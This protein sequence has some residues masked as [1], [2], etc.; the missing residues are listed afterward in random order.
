MQ[1][2]KVSNTIKLEVRLTIELIDIFLIKI[3]VGEETQQPCDSGLH[4]VNTGGLQ[5]LHKAAGQ[6]HRYTVFIPELFTLTRRKFQQT[7][8]G[9]WLTIE[10]IK[11]NINCFILTH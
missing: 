6:A 4:Q 8:L 7:R 10:I 11:H 9:E 3:F 1:N 2:Q 5:G